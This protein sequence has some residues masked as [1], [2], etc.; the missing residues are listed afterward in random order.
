MEVAR[1]SALHT[2]HLFSLRNIPGTHFFLRPS[3]PQGYSMDERIKAKKNSTTPTEIKPTN[4]W[5]VAQ[6][7]NH[8]HHCVPPFS[9]KSSF[10]LYGDS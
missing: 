10:L 2:G 4:L 1:F 3:Q 7:F 8:L 6:Y 9:V 5:H